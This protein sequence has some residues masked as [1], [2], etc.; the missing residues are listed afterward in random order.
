MKKVW[1]ELNYIVLDL[2]YEA[3][4]RLNL[5]LGVDGRHFNVDL[6]VWKL[7]ELLPHFVN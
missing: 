2:S 4:F 1:G 5:D 3:I 7:F 6:I